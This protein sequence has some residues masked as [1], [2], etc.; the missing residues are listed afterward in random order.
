MKLVRRRLEI[1]T[2]E[3]FVPLLQPARYKGAWGGRGGG[4]DHFF[5]E[6]LIDD[7]L[8]E[9]GLLSVCI[10]EVQRTLAQS[11]KRLL[12]SKLTTFGLGEADGFKVFREAIETPGDGIIIFNGMQDHTAESIKSLE[13]FKRAW[14]TEAQTASATSLKL[15]RPTLRAEGSE[16]WFAWNPKRAPD[17]EHPENSVDG[18]LRGSNPPPRS[19]VVE[20]QWRDN[21]WFPK[22]LEEE[23][24]YDRQHRQPEDYA[25]IWDG[26]Y[27]TRS[28]ARVFK[29]WSVAE[30]D[31]PANATFRFG[32]DFGFSV[33]PSVLS[34]SFLGRW[35]SEPG[36]SRVIADDASRDLF[37]D[38][39]AY[40]VGCDVDHTPALFA[41]DAPDGRWQNPYGDV[42][43][44]GAL[45]WPI[46]ADSSNPQTIS[47]L[48]RM[49]LNV[50]PAKK[51]PGSI[52]EGV[53]F[54]KSYRI[55]IHVRCKKTA[56]EFLFYS[57]KVDKA[58]GLILPVLEDKKNHVIDATRYAVEDMRRAKGFFG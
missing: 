49:G 35:E 37:I 6:K 24:T 51:G 3:V 17:V 19:V 43:I 28:E 7:S 39:E 32:A 56:D 42:G 11:S 47:F 15:L 44:P 29:N 25:H 57:F 53:N 13:G 26:A 40:R 22:E 10:R 50:R 34:R 23:E 38:Y 36:K 55:W 31:T 54:L 58:T 33:D 1:P 8:Y 27:E 46:I 14:W 30:Y 45:S 16:L 18:L 41:G 5:A 21:P 12:E 52:E 2:A 4:K 20:A 9:R 48:K